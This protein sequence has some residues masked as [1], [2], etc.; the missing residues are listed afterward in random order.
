MSNLTETKLDLLD[1]LKDNPDF[2]ILETDKNLGPV[3]M[4][5]TTY[6]KNMLD[7]RLLNNENYRELSEQE[8]STMM[9]DLAF[10]IKEIIKYEQVNELL[11]NKK[12]FSQRGF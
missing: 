3:I 12:V 5:R 4:N 9:E 6:I 2:I 7:Q 1:W 10:D 8:A 11:Y